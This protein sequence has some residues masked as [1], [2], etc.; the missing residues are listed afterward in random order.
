MK[1]NVFSLK[2]SIIVASVCCM[3]FGVTV[4]T[5]ITQVLGVYSVNGREYPRRI[6]NN[7]SSGGDIDKY[8]KPEVKLHQAG[9]GIDVDK[10]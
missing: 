2:K 8:E 9:G 10:K 7:T 1:K 5:G 4:F 6:I 3:V